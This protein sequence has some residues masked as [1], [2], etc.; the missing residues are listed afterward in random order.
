MTRHLLH[1]DCPAHNAVAASVP[2]AT[3]TFEEQVAHS[4]EDRRLYKA[5]LLEE[6][7][8]DLFEAD[9]RTEAASLPGSWS[10]A[11]GVSNARVEAVDDK[12]KPT[13]RL[14]YEFRNIGSLIASAMLRCLNLRISPPGR[15]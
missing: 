13:V 15:S 3:R 12:I 7:L 8:R 14:G 11:L 9:G 4:P 1:V 5:D 10:A 2:W 6:R